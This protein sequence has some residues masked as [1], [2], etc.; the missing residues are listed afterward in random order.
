MPKMVEVPTS[1]AEKFR[2]ARA[3]AY[4]ADVAVD[5]AEARL[6]AA[7]ERAKLAAGRVESATRLLAHHLA[8]VPG[9]I[10]S[11]TVPLADLEEHLGDVMLC[12]EAG[13]DLPVVDEAGDP[14]RWGIVGPKSSHGVTS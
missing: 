9:A 4:V 1:V 3:D 2:R 12:M 7:T 5:D 6:K 10:V 8:G 11:G 13:P 14:V